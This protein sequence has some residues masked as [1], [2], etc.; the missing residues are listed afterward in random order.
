[1]PPPIGEIVPPLLSFFAVLFS[2]GIVLL[3]LALVFVRFRGG[4]AA[5]CQGQEVC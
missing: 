1:M 4:A 2:I 5:W 3:M